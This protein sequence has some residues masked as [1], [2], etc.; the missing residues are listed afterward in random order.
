MRRAARIFAICA[1]AGSAALSVAGGWAAVTAFERMTAATLEAQRD[2][3]D[4][5]AEIAVDGLKV[6]LTGA[7][8]SETARFQFLR[9]ISEVLPARRFRDQTTVSE[10][11]TAAEPDYSLQVLRNLSDI[12]LIGLI[13]GNGYSSGLVERVARLD[14]EAQVTDMLERVERTPPAL[15]QPSVEFGLDALGQLDRAKLSVT[16]GEVTLSGVVPDQETLDTLTRELQ[17][18]TPDG[19]ELI[20]GLTAPRPVISPFRFRASAMPG[21]GV[22]IDACTA[23]TG[24]EA[25]ALA[26]R[27][28]AVGATVDCQI[29]LGAPSQEW[30]GVM[31]AALE[32]LGG[33]EAAEIDLTDTRMH[34]VGY[35][36][37]DREA[38]GVVADRLTGLL[39]APFTLEADLPPLPP[40]VT[41]E[42]TPAPPRFAAE[43]GKDGAVLLTGDLP[44]AF[45]RGTTETFAQARFGYDMVD[46]DT[47]ARQGL[48]VDWASR[49]VGGLEALALLQHGQFELTEGA[50][51][52]QGVSTATQVE[53]QVRE[54]LAQA[55]PPRTRIFVRIEVIDTPAPV[56]AGVVFPPGLCGEQIELVLAR[57][58]INFPPSETEIDEASL[59][60]VDEIARI[61]AKCPG[62]RF[63]IAG[64]TDSQGRESSNLA[65]SQ[66]RA[67]SVLGALLDRGIDLVFLSTRG[68][69][70]S[71]PIAEND[72]EEGRAA[73]RRIEF[74]MLGEPSEDVA[75]D[76]ALEGA[77]GA[78]EESRGDAVPADEDEGDAPDAGADDAADAGSGDEVGDFVEGSGDGPDA[79]SGDEIADVAEGSGDG[80][81]AGSGDEDA[82]DEAAVDAPDGVPADSEAEDVAEVAADEAPGDADG[83]VPDNDVTN[84]PEAEDAPAPNT[85]GNILNRPRPRPQRLPQIQEEE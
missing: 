26:A 47:V 39:P 64:H 33:L 45:L 17:D 55:L 18:N 67:D 14:P 46:N 57:N 63:E 38:F 58:Q 76:V 42:G 70:E 35:P 71:E 52:L 56:A 28:E 10:V 80:P 82:V 43:R 65:L 30:T 53:D 27:A 79:G 44:D 8:P 66:A 81:D 69:G 32:A 84:D 1:L 24:A 48:P 15:W 54:I 5:W 36:E 49:A 73:N 22:R 29:G 75:E 59:P 2:E 25:D 16:P 9:R 74:R 62:A 4:D 68:Y 83:V 6:T 41:A 19:V 51:R 12:S 85:S 13:P 3:G 23:E 7:A 11:A 37:Q 78:D 50:V 60:I 72:T 34:L 21:E 61:L 31:L 40:P 77:A 20:L